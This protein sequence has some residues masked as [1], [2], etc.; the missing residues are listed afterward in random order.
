[1]EKYY[2]ICRDLRNAYHWAPESI[3]RLPLKRIFRIHSETLVDHK[4]AEDE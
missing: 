1:M 2:I 4:A 3:D